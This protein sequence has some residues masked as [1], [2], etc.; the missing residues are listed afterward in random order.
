MLE[1]RNLT[2]RF[3]GAKGETGP[4]LA[5]DDL[6]FSVEEGQLFT[7]LGPSGCGK[8]TTLRCVAGLDHPDSGAIEV[9][10]RV[11]YSSETKTLVPVNERGL[12]MVFQSYAIWPHMNVFKNVAFPL[13]VLPRGKRPSKKE[14]AGRVERALT[15]V[16]LEKLSSRQATD[17][18]GGQQQRLALARALVMEPPMLLL[19]EPLSN[20]DAKL[21]HQMRFELKRLQDELN[22]TTVYVTHD[23]IEALAMSDVIGVMRQGKFEQVGSPQEIYNSPAS[24]FVADFIGTSNFV[25][26]LISRSTDKGYLVE[27]KAGPALV[28]STQAFA[29]GEA[30]VFA[31]RPEHL[32]IEAGQASVGEPGRWAGRIRARAFLGEVVDHIIEVGP[33]EIQAR[34]HP[35][36]SFDEGSLVTVVISPDSCSLIRGDSAL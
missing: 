9:A 36:F 21:R 11:L 31:V 1:V 17:L 19:D 24:K 25:E 27:T 6:S 5:V 12:G 20:L 8:T 32:E 14:I 3:P 29:V 23:Q 16:Q 4:V 33:V 26:G 7:L 30:V 13:Q 2:K 18:S 10:G 15:V 34:C 28:S 35:S 22:I